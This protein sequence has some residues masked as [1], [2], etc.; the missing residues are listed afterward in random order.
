[1][2]EILIPKDNS[3]FQYDFDFF[4]GRIDM[5][6]LTEYG[7]FKVVEGEPGRTLCTKKIEK[8]MLLATINLPPYVLDIDDVTFEKTDNRRFT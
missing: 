1:M 4:L 7:L 2:S 3:Q 8:A 6:F 5:V